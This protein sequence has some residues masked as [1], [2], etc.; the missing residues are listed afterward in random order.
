MLFL[1]KLEVLLFGGNNNKVELKKC[2]FSMCAGKKLGRK[3]G[4]FVK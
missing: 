3:N 4:K 1:G 2:K